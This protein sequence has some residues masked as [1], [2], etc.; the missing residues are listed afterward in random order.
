[1]AIK[2]VE[3]STDYFVDQRVQELQASDISDPEVALALEQALLTDE[4]ITF[5]EFLESY[6][7]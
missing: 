7:K 2:I 5:C 6:N 4:D 1:M 3:Q